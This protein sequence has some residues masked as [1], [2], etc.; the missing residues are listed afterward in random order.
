M[1]KQEKEAVL[2]PC[3]FFGCKNVSLEELRE[4]FRNY[5]TIGDLIAVWNRRA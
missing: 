4:P 5:A 3:L 2:K 1:E